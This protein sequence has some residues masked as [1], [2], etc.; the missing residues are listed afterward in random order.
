MPGLKVNP[1]V[2][3]R[4][5]LFCF[6]YETSMQIVHFDAARREHIPTSNLQPPVQQGRALTAMPGVLKSAPC[7][8]PGLREIFV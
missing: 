8:A 7:R 6:S 4:G 5:L 1:L 3:A 2:S